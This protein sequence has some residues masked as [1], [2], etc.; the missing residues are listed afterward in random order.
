MERRC[1]RTEWHGFK[2]LSARLAINH[3]VALSFSPSTRGAM[4]DLLAHM[5][6]AEQLPLAMGT[7]S[8]TSCVITLS[9]VSSFGQNREIHFLLFTPC[10][11]TASALFSLA[12]GLVGERRK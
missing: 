12:G 7:H 6:M 9:N 1:V 10:A 4:Q 8:L 3:K 2:V 11:W 5:F